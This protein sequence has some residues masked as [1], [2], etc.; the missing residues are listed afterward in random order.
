M[1][2]EKP[3]KDKRAK[4]LEYVGKPQAQGDQF[5]SMVLK[6]P[7]KFGLKSKLAQI[8][9]QSL[10]ELLW[11]ASDNAANAKPKIKLIVLSGEH[12][13]KVFVDTRL[14]SACITN[15]ASIPFS[16]KNDKLSAFVHSFDAAVLK[17]Q[18]MGQI[19][20]N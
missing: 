10:F 19:V 14:G 9:A 2:L 20:V 12:T 16:A 3:P 1:N 15:K 8:F 5:F 11:E 7:S 6:Y 13:E 18:Y 17:L 4:L